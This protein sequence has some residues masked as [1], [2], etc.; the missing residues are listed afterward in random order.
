MMRAS[1]IAVCLIAVACERAPPDGGGSAPEASQS[2]PSPDVR[3]SSEP[4]HAPRD[5][6]AEVVDLVRAAAAADLRTEVV[7]DVRRFAVS[8]RWAFLTA[9]P[10]T[11][12]GAPIDR[13]AKHSA[14]VVADGNV[15]DGLCALAERRNGAWTLVRMVIGSTD[16]PYAAWPEKYGVPRELLFGEE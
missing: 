12:A 9:T 7:L 15:N 6:R 3:S 11:P 13:R 10:R 5:D 14:H 2:T 16:A 8:D 4:A 1:C